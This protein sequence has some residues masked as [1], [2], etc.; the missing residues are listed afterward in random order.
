MF[1]PYHTAPTP[2]NLVARP[3][4]ANCTKSKRFCEGYNP[5]MHFKAP[6]T[7]NVD[8][9]LAARSLMYSN[10][11]HFEG[12][13]TS[14]LSTPS[15]RAIAPT[16]PPLHH[17][18]L[19]GNNNLSQMGAM[20]AGWGQDASL[21][22]SSQIPLSADGLRSFPA[23]SPGLPPDATPNQIL[24][25]GRHASMSGPHPEYQSWSGSFNP[26]QM[27]QRSA[28]G[29]SH[30]LANLDLLSTMAASQDTID[31]YSAM[32]STGDSV[33]F[34]FSRASDYDTPSTT[35]IAA[36]GDHPLA[37]DHPFY[38]GLTAQVSDPRLDVAAQGKFSHAQLRSDALRMSPGHRVQKRQR[39]CTAQRTTQEDIALRGLYSVHHSI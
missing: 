28:F 13:A 26:D 5:R 25:P 3:I 29:R 33:G 23:L 4:C 38:P 14:G 24:R 8:D 16:P 12:F 39:A 19:Y 2:T 11:A 32:P 27:R 35:R 15:L 21:G 18:S 1:D 7:G 17:R 31:A 10:Q 20:P 36:F 22:A 9:M 37:T 34:Q 30:A 6:P